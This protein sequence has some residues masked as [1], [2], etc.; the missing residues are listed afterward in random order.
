ML[1]QQRLALGQ[2]DRLDAVAHEL[3]VPLLK[4]GHAAAAKNGQAEVQVVGD[5]QAAGQV[6]LVEIIVARLVGDAVENPALAQV[7]APGVVAVAGQ[8]GVVQIE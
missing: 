4:L 3:A 7:V 8:E 1:G 5:V 6:V 2:D